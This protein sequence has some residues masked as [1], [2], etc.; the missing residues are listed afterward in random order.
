MRNVGCIAH[1]EQNTALNAKLIK[2]LLRRRIVRQ[3]REFEIDH[4]E[5]GAAAARG[6]VDHFEMEINT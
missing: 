5:L 4:M 6:L 1:F 2:L 3:G